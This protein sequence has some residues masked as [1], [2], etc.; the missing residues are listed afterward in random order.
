MIIYEIDHMFIQNKQNK[1]IQQR[2]IW[3]SLQIP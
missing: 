3:K 1:N 2:M